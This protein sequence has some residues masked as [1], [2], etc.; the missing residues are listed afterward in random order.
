MEKLKK[1][2]PQ[3]LEG[4]IGWQLRDMYTECLSDF[5]KYENKVINKWQEKINSE[6]TEKLK[7]PVMV[8]Y[9]GNYHVT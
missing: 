6:L 8:C 7:Q 3:L 5:D 2:A 9:L 1:I 4:D